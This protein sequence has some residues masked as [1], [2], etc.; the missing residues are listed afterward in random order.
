M[1]IKSILSI[2]GSDVLSVS[3][4]QTVQDVLALFVGREIGFVAVQREDGKL[5]GTISER[6]LCHALNTM[7][8]AGLSAVVEDVMTQK[9][10]SCAPDDTLPKAMALMTGKRTRHVVVMEHDEVKGIVSIGDVV[11]HRL[12]EVLKDEAA[13][14]DY[15]K[16]TG[17]SYRS[18]A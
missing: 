4:D 9:V 5:L 11:K 6:D 15:I 16:G 12:D 7:K 13:L 3:P 10:V 1:Q 8:E 14:R 18:S 17:Y 2:K